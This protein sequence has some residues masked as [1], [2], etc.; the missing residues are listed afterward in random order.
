M[1]NSPVA[2]YEMSQTSDMTCISQHVCSSMP[3]SLSS[4]LLLRL[5]VAGTLTKEG[6]PAQ[7]ENPV[8][9]LLRS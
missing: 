7:Q 1:V 5:S 8:G 2:S 6:G 3:L 9:H 4:R